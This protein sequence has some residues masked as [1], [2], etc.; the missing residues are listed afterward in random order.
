VLPVIAYSSLK[1]A[2]CDSEQDQA[3]LFTSAKNNAFKELNSLITSNKVNVNQR[4]RLGWT[5]LH[6]ALI[7]KNFKCVKLLLDNGA[8]P[9]LPDEF[10]NV[11]ATA[12]QLGLNPLQVLV[13]REEEFSDRLNS[14][15][16]FKGFTPL[17]YA[18]LTDSLELV[19]LLLE[20]GADPLVENEMGHRACEYSENEAIRKCLEEGER[21]AVER[22]EA[23]LRE[24]R[25]K[26]PLE[27]RIKQR[28]IGQEAAVQIVSSVIR[29]KE[30]GWIDEE[31]T[32]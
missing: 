5:A 18:V 7:N 16:T 9:N 30:N 27:D 25:R 23:R 20:A 6:V 4:H 26:F 31:V 17:H 22:R 24:E 2:E 14:R 32:F 15:A 12:R 19:G 29:R 11:N 3:S 8:D 13:A 10:V 21:K 1:R 28:I